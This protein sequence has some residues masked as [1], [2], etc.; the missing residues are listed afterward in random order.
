MIRLLRIRHDVW[1][2]CE[3]RAGDLWQW[4]CPDTEATCWLDFL[5]AF[6]LRRRASAQ[7]S[8]NN[9]GY[10]VYGRKI[11]GGKHDS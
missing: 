6:F 7:F 2:W 5:P 11:P 3:I 4:A 8:L 10:D 1:Y 9:R